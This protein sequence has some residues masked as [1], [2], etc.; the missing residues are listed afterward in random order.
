V[1]T[2]AS[3]YQKLALALWNH[4]TE[5]KNAVEIAGQLGSRAQRF[6]EWERNPKAIRASVWCLLIKRQGISLLDLAAVIVAPRI[7]GGVSAPATATTARTKFVAPLLKLL[8][9]ERT[10]ADAQKMFG[11][12]TQGTFNHWEMGRRD[13]PLWRFIQAIDILATR[14]SSFCEALNFKENL[15]NFGFRSSRTDFSTQ[16]FS[17]PWTPTVF[18]ALQTQRYLRQQRH[19]TKKLARQLNL[20]R[21]QV[22]ESLTVLA[23]LELIIFDNKFYRTRKGQFYAPPTLTPATLDRLHSYWFGKSV[24]LLVQP[25]L[26]KIEEH[27]LSRESLRKIITWVTELREKIR[28]EVK[29]SEPETVVHIHWQIAEMIPD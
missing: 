14:L 23:D 4:A 24:D 19:D 1:I 21:E 27:A 28:E 29:R 10:L 13:I 20:T 16:F 5:G 18:L 25:G 11:L 6:R 12:T 9:G 2:A 3:N 17:L 26:H 7:A 22:E 15:A 8:R